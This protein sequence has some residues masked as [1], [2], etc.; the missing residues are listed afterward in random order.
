MKL[1]DAR[2]EGNHGIGR[3][4][5]ELGVRL[6][7]FQ[8]IE[9]RGNPQDPLDP[10]RLSAHLYRT[11]P[12]L[13]FS[14]G[15]NSPVSSP[16]PFV[17]TIHDLNHLVIPENSNALKRAYFR[18]LVLPAVRRSAAVL[19]VSEFSRQAICEWAQVPLSKV[20]N[21][22]NGISS[23]FTTQGQKYIGIRPYILYVGNHKPHK[24][25]ARLLQ[26]FAVSKLA[27]ELVLLS[28]GDASLQYRNEIERL[29]L[30]RDVDFIGP[31]SDE[32]LAMLYRGAVALVLVSLYEG[33]GLPIVEAMACGTPVLTSNCAS[34]PEVAGHA[35]LV[36]DPTSIES[37][38]NGLVKIA[39]DAELRL[40]LVTKGID[41]AKRFSWDATALKVKA[42]LEL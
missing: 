16:C 26:S 24:N 21:V 20:S 35:G 4:A 38:A 27:P 37:I 31:Q 1:I 29:N 5:R 17:P 9:L 41:V 7:D 13:Y 36:V 3:F 33:F 8:P 19:T 28:T 14:P 10:M 11:R 25:F 40:S 34:M 18:H 39:Y 2:W 32:Q 6:R 30:G 15:Y 12:D 23:A 22:G 42:A